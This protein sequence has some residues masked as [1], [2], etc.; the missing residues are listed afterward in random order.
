MD[1]TDERKPA[2]FTISRTGSL[3]WLTPRPFG[4]AKCSTG[5][6]IF[7]SMRDFEPAISASASSWGSPGR[8]GW[9]RVWAPMVCP[10]L[11]IS[12][13]SPHVIMQSSS[14]ARS[15]TA[16]LAS[17]S[18]KISPP[19]TFPALLIVAIGVREGRVACGG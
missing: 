1:V 14:A 9:V 16:S 5:D 17:T 4:Y 12:S 11:L 19:R 7:S 6:L 3:K 10:P 2:F 8:L 15:V 18:R 13:I